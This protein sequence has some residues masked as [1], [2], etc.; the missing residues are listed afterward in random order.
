MLT[1]GYPLAINQLISGLLAAYCIT[2]I[3]APILLNSL[4]TH[5]SAEL[6]ELAGRDEDASF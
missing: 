3:R 2:V 6:R 5:L 4:Q 1:P